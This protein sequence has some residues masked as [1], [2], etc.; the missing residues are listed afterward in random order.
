LISLW[1]TSF[2]LDGTAPIE[3]NRWYHLALTYDGSTFKFYVN[4]QLQRSASLPYGL[5]YTSYGIE[6]GGY[7]VDYYD[8]F[9]DS[10]YYDNHLFAGAI[11]EVSIYNRALT[12]TENNLPLLRRIEWQSQ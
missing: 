10:H 7:L 11:D 8:P 5:N 2:S 1:D 4:N 3:L 9:E 6:I 12:P